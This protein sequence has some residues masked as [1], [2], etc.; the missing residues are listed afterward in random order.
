MGAIQ[1]SINNMLGTAAAGVALGKHAKEQQETKEIAKAGMA[2]KKAE[3]ELNLNELEEQQS[4]VQDELERLNK[5][6]TPDEKGGWNAPGNTWGLDIGKEIEK[7]NLAMSVLQEKIKAKMLLINSYKKALGEKTV[8]D[9][10]GGKN[11]G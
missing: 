4:N 2:E 1:S 10:I 11:N 5:G 9:I 7:R 8:E 6:Q 3:E